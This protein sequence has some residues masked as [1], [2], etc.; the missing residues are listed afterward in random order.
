MRDDVLDMKLTDMTRRAGCVRNAAGEA[1]DIRG[2]ESVTV[3][4]YPQPDEVLVEIAIPPENI[5]AD[6]PG[7]RFWIDWPT[8]IDAL[9][10][11]RYRC[12][13]ALQM[14]GEPSPM[15]LPNRGNAW[16]RIHDDTP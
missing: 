2:A 12:T 15:L 7:N 10:A 9:P 5:I 6:D 3:R 14:P 11:G 8:G 16:L 13:L 4:A 1:V